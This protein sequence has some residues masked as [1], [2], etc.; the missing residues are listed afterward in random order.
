MT[1]P[2]SP[3]IR[4]HCDGVGRIIV[5]WR[6]VDGATD[7][8]IYL[9][10]VDPPSGLEDELDEGDEY[11]NGVFVWYSTPYAES[12]YVGVT[13][14]NLAA[15]ESALSTTTHVWPN[16]DAQPDQSGSLRNVRRRN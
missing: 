11:S 5:R 16:V 1:A 9:D 6:A 10:S 4:V 3:T 2:A 14:L 12:L 7:Y 15:E 13:A 8:N